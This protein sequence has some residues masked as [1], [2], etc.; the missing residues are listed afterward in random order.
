MFRSA[1]AHIWPGEIHMRPA[2]P[3]SC[4]ESSLDISFEL[5][6]WEGS[7]SD[8]D[9]LTGELEAEGGSRR[10]RREV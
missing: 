1:L 9:A 6:E 4:L 2:E 7:I 8:V 10:G 5:Q 3:L